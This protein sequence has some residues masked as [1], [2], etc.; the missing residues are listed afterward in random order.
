MKQPSPPIDWSILIG[1]VV[2]LAL[3]LAFWWGV[4]YLAGTWVGSS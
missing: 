1:W 3:C 4:I 2:I